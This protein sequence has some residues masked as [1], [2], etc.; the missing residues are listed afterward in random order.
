MSVS[1]HPILNVQKIKVACL[2]C[3]T[4]TGRRHH[5]VCLQLRTGAHGVDHHA[6]LGGHVLQRR[7]EPHQSAVPG[8]R[9]RRASEQLC[10]HRYVTRVNKKMISDSLAHCT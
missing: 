3:L 8:D 9:G 10:E 1:E 2:P 4:E 6:V 7:P 5:S